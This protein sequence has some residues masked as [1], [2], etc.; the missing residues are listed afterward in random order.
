[1]VSSTP[2]SDT[3]RVPERVPA[4]HVRTLGGLRVFVRL[5]SMAA[6]GGILVALFVLTGL[7]AAVLAPYDPDQI[8][9]QH[10]LQSPS[11]VHLL[12]TDNQ[13]RDLLSRIIFGARVSL[14]ISLLVIL[15]T[16]TIGTTLGILGG[17]LGGVT[18]SLLMRITDVS[19]AFPGILIALTVVCVFTMGSTLRE[20]VDPQLR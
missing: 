14:S 8:D 19:L 13:G 16:A 15:V 4:V 10:T 11:R 5:H 1:M 9:V 6:V 3:T 2:R 17:Y 20:V 7:L 18:D 12:G